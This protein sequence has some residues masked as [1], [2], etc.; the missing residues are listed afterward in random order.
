MGAYVDWKDCVNKYAALPKNGGAVEMQDVFISEAEDEVNATLAPRYTVP[1]SPCPGI[2]KGLVI[3]LVYWKANLLQKGAQTVKT[4]YDARIKGILDGSILIVNSGDAAGA[5]GL[6][7]ARTAY[8]S[9]CRPLGDT[10]PSC[11]S[12]YCL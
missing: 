7:A 1:F 2:V 9:S 3:D 11:N 4:Y 6:R 5:Y 8:V 10:D 12:G